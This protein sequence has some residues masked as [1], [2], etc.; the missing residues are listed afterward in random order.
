[1]ADTMRCD[2]PAWNE[3]DPDGVTLFNEF[4]FGMAGLDTQLYDPLR[5]AAPSLHQT[6]PVK[7]FSN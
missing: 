1:M 2:A 4:R 3:P 7:H 5:A 6:S